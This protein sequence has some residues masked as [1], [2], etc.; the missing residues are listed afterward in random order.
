MST[1]NEDQRNTL[2]AINQRLPSFFVHEVEQYFKPMS[3]DD[4]IRFAERLKDND[5]APFELYHALFTKRGFTFPQ[6]ERISSIIENRN[7]P[8]VLRTM[9]QKLPNQR[10]QLDFLK[11]VFSEVLHH[12][13]SIGGEKSIDL[14]EEDEEHVRL[15]YQHIVD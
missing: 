1:W 12:K 4:L 3:N 5:A 2:H 8:F 7:M 10:D 6:M 9:M 14:G 13:K 11:R 15:S